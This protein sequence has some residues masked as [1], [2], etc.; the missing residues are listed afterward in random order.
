MVLKLGLHTHY[1]ELQLADSFVLDM[2]LESKVGHSVKVEDC[3]ALNAFLQAHLMNFIKTHFIDRP[4]IVPYANLITFIPRFLSP[5]ISPI[6]EDQLFESRDTLVHPDI[7][8]VPGSL[9]SL[10]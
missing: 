7:A 9:S 3:A 5:P 8:T 6:P 1:L 2:A 4:L 10:H